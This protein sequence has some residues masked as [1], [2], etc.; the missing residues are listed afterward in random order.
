[1]TLMVYSHY[2]SAF[3][4]LEICVL[5][6]IC[7]L[8]QN[9]KLELS[10]AMGFIKS[11]CLFMILSAWQLIPLFTDYFHGNLMRPAS[12]F[13]LM[14]SAGDFFTSAISNEALNQ[15]GIG[16]VLL[17]TLVFGW[18]FVERESKY[19]W[20]YVLGVAI[21][22][23]ITTAFPW[24]YVA[25]TPLSIIQF[26]YRYTSYAAAFLAIVLAKALSKLKYSTMN[27]S[28]VTTIIILFLGAL[29]SG[30][31][32]SD[33]TRNRNTDN[34]I[35]ILTSR[36]HGQYKT[37]RDPSDSPIIV[38]NNSY[39]K[40]F[41]YGALYGET[42]YMPVDAFKHCR[43]VLNRVTFINGKRALIHQESQPNRIVYKIHVKQFSSINLPALVYKHT[44][45]KVNGNKVK[46]E[47]SDR[48]TVQLKLSKGN[49]KVDVSYVP[50]CLL[51]FLMAISLISWI[52]V[53]I[54]NYTRFVKLS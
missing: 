17:A 53:I 1:M 18:L 4:S 10:K 50:T 45:V 37:L 26:P 11:I 12:G 41:S 9:H 15:G 51:S 14:Q 16:V 24:Q 43:T 13:M 32:Y 42:D 20:I 23:M 36:R 29:Y 38:T 39:N 35:S 47:T 5:I 49:Y 46:E 44:V 31:V 40:Q 6:L 27:S 19:M 34:S 8:I 3:I 30:S 48:G 28:I 22:W 54:I 52:L 25:K 2:V 33:I 7:Y 21:T